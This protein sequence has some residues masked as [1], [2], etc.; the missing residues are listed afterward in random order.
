MGRPCLLYPKVKS[1]FRSWKERDSLEWLQSQQLHAMV[2]L[3]YRTTLQLMLGYDT[4]IRRTSVM[5]A[6]KNFA[7]KIATKPLQ[8]K[9]WLILTAYKNLPL[10]YPAVPSPTPAY[11]LA[12]IPHDRHSRVHNH[13]LRSSKVDGFHVTWK[14]LCN[15]IVVINSNL[16]PIS[17]VSEIRRRRLLVEKRTF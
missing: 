5:T 7:L 11:R 4:V 14:S 2:T 17:T 16:G 15:F 1:D 13:L 8:I 3:P 9:T 10:P 6:D 12:T